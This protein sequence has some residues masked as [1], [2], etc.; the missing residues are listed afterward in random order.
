MSF[1]EP[2]IC[3]FLRE[4]TTDYLILFA[5]CNYFNW[6]LKWRWLKV[7]LGLRAKPVEPLSL[8]SH[9]KSAKKKFFKMDKNFFSE[10]KRVY[11]KVVKQK[12]INSSTFKTQTSLW[13]KKNK[14]MLSSNKLIHAKT[15]LWITFFFVWFFLLT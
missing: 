6:L 3:F 4:I 5:H 8:I 14:F 7:P 11:E 15:L 12:Q 13:R 1:W 10:R 2:P 9:F